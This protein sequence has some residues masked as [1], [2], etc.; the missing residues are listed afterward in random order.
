MNSVEVEAVLALRL[1]DFNKF[2]HI[3]AVDE[4]CASGVRSSELR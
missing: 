2:L 4:V 1:F 3:G